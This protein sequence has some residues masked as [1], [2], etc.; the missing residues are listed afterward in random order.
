VI[1]ADAHALYGRYLHGFLED[2]LGLEV[3]ADVQTGEA[4]LHA[5]AALQPH[6]LLIDVTSPRLGGIPLV[7]RLVERHPEVRVIA[8]GLYGERQLTRAALEAGAA[9]FV[10]RQ[11]AVD[12]LP[13]VL[14]ELSGAR[15]S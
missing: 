10:E 15:P 5:V 8:L 4:T 9:A 7:R 1:V 3:V 14:G 11:D 6:A 2:V 12:H 13:D